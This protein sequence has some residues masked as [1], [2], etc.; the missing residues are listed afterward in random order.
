MKTLFLRYFSQSL[1]ISLEVV[2]SLRPLVKG[3]EDHYKLRIVGQSK[4]CVWSLV[5]SKTLLSSQEKAN[6]KNN[7]HLLDY[8]FFVLF[9]C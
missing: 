8:F 1:V 3:E 7:N 9:L 6:V 4:W 2:E 5:D